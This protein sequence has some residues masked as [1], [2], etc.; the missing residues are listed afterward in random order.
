MAQ[1]RNLSSTEPRGVQQGNAFDDS[2][3]TGEVNQM[4]LTGIVVWAGVYINS[5]TVRI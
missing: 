3:R 1:N 5:L 4:T 2:V